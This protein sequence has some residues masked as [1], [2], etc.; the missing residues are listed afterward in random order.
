[1]L[2]RIKCKYIDTSTYDL[3]RPVSS[4]RPELYDLPKVH[5]KDCQLRPILSM[6][7]LPQNGLAKFLVKALTWL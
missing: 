3:I 2:S 7:G 6:V 1:M 5:K 4:Q